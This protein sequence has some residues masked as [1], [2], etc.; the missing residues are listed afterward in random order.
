MIRS[1]SSA[2]IPAISRARREASTAKVEV[3]W[4]SAAIRRCLIPVLV[5]IHSSLVSTI[6]SRSRL[7]SIFSGREEPVPVILDLSICSPSG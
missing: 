5:V 7:V 4:P 3:Y 6:R 1:S 2:L